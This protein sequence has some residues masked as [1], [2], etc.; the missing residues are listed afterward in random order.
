M[1]ERELMEKLVQHLL[2][3]QQRM[4]SSLTAKQG[5]PKLFLSIPTIIDQDKWQLGTAAVLE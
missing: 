3:A 5:E 4:K 1:Q 2:Q